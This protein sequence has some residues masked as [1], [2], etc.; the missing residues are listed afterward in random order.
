VKFVDDDED[1]G[2][3]HEAL[4]LSHNSII[5]IYTND[6]L[7]LSLITAANS[8]LYSVNITLLDLSHRLRNM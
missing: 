5:N 1:T 7:T 3:V 2:A 8:S 6:N 4:N